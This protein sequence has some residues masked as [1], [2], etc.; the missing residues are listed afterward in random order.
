[1][2]K[3]FEE[4]IGFHLTILCR[5]RCWI[6]AQFGEGFGIE[7]FDILA[8]LYVVAILRKL[9]ENPFARILIELF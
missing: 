9:N 8:F 6:S 5:N 1:L 4:A 7:V 3:E 2:C